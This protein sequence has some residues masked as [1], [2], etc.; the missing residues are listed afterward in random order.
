MKILM[1]LFYFKIFGYKSHNANDN[2][3]LCLDFT[4]LKN[5][6]IQ[7]ISIFEQILLGDKVI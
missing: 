7:N 3:P 1:E 2:E 6:F 4:H 5:G